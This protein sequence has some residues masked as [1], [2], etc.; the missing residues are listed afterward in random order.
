M[1]K[2][3]FTREY[4]ITLPGES[5]LRT[6]LVIARGWLRRAAAVAVR[7]LT[8]FFAWHDAD[9]SGIAMQFEK[10]KH[11]LSFNLCGLWSVSL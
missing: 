7:G 1:I 10:H 6:W 3:P 4:I 8:G 2:T 9:H 11:S 5:G